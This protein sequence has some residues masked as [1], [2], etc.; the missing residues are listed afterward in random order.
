MNRE[1][2]NKKIL[3]EKERKVF[4]VNLSHDITEDHL[5]KYFSQFGQIE[6][7]RIIKD[8]EVGT[9][10]GFGFVLFQDR[11]S[12]IRVFEQGDFHLINGKQVYISNIRL[13]VEKSC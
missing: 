13:N 10:R 3:D 5:R 6:E 1:T 8:K 4:V 2:S 7:V 11:V 12:Y 9:I